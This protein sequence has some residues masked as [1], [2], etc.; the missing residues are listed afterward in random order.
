MAHKRPLV[1]PLHTEERQP[2]QYDA[3]RGSPHRQVLHPFPPRE[4]RDR[5]KRDRDLD[6]GSGLRPT[7]MPV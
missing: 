6:D 4:N 2:C 1:G 5:S 7:M 3:N